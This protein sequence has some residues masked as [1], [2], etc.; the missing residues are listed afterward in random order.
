MEVAA[1]E[2]TVEFSDFNTHTELIRSTITFSMTS[3]TTDAG[4]TVIFTASVNGQEAADLTAPFT[5]TWSFDATT[6]TLSFESRQTAFHFIGDATT[7]ITIPSEHT[8]V[9]VNGVETFVN[10]PGLTTTIIATGSTNVIVDLPAV[11]TTMD[12]AADSY[13]LTVEQFTISTGNTAAGQEAA[14]KYCGTQVF[15]DGAENS[16]CVMSYDIT[17]TL[18]TSAAALYLHANGLTTSFALPGITTTFLFPEEYLMISTVSAFREF[19]FS[20]SRWINHVLPSPLIF[21]SKF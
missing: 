2:T 5:T 9:T 19:F 14:S 6:L 3:A 8:H 20:F 4:S 15:A 1:A 7:E 12:I 11:T 13:V 16:P 10:L 21:K 17:I 18:P